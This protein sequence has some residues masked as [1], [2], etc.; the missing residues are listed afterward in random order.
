MMPEA[1]RYQA[2]DHASRNIGSVYGLQGELLSSKSRVSLTDNF[3]MR[4]LLVQLSGRS[5]S[6]GPSSSATR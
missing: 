2:D 5:S 6:R 1:Q 3:V 4:V